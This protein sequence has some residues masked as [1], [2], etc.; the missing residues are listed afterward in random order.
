MLFKVFAEFL[1]AAGVL[2]CGNLLNP[3]AQRVCAVGDFLVTDCHGISVAAQI[4]NRTEQKIII[5]V[6]RNN[7]INFTASQETGC[8]PVLL[9]NPVRIGNNNYFP[10]VTEVLINGSISSAM[11]LSA[12]GL[13]SK[14][15]W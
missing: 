1:K 11:S 14:M 7:F 15:L 13:E 10:G 9:V 4:V 3:A 6:E 8:H 2:G 12:K 5:V